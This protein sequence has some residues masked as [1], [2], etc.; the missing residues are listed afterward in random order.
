[1]QQDSKLEEITQQQKTLR[2]WGLL[3]RPPARVATVRLAADGGGCPSPTGNQRLW[4][5]IL[6]HP[7]IGLIVLQPFPGMR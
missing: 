7:K 3:Q 1:M 6:T 2:G 4:A 5:Y